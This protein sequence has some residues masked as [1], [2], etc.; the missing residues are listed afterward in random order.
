MKVFVD[1]QN[2]I[3]DVGST[4]NESLTEVDIADNNQNPFIGWS[5]AKICCYSVIVQNGA[6]IAFYPYVT[7]SIIDS[8]DRLGLEIE[9]LEKIVKD[10]QA[11][12]DDLLTNII[13][14]I[15]RKQL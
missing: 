14:E 3:R 8:I 10:Q 13:P 4:K 1:D 7:T 11:T 15:R 6:V 5:K 12:I 9:A 2:R